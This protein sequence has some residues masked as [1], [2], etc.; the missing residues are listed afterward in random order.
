MWFFLLPMGV[1]FLYA[2]KKYAHLFPLMI[3]QFLRNHQQIN[4]EKKP[5]LLIKKA[6]C[7]EQAHL[8]TEAVIA[9]RQILIRTKSIDHA[10]SLCKLLVRQ[11]EWHEIHEISQ[12]YQYD[13]RLLLFYFH[14]LLQL[15]KTDMPGIDSAFLMHPLH[16]NFHEDQ[17][18]GALKSWPITS[19]VNTEI[20]TDILFKKLCQ[21]TSRLRM[22]LFCQQVLVAPANVYQ[23]IAQLPHPEWLDI[24]SASDLYQFAMIQYLLLKDSMILICKACQHKQAKYQLFCHYCGAIESFSEIHYVEKTIIG[25]MV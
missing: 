6:Q 10:Y 8:Y 2:Y 11:G 23:S 9:Y 3:P 21:H 25:T 16:P 19:L 24:Q 7:Y 18:T 15:N 22:Q 17:L 20:P 13:F 12:I 4:K 5:D 14:S 1:Y